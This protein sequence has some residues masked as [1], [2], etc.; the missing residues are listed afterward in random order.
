MSKRGEIIIIEDDL[1]DQIIIK[2]ALEELNVKNELRFFMDPEDAYGY[3]MSMSGKPFMIFCDVNMPKLT[4]IEL[5]KKI[6]ATDYLRRKAIPFI[7]LTTSDEQKHID[8]AYE[9][10]NLQGYFKKG[11][12]LNEIKERV[13]TILDYWSLSM[14][15]S[16]K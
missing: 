5:K 9:V 15:P 11:H 16:D 14:H 1:D 12:S 13:K 3:L 10:A 2:E 7:F 6:D 8:R 4:G